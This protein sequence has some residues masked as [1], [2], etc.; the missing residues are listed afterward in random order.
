M[1]S[2]S[3]SASTIA[4]INESNGEKKIFYSDFLTSIVTNYEIRRIHCLNI[5]Y[6]I[7]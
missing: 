4:M 2:E 3:K 6:V 7:I 1:E 5:H